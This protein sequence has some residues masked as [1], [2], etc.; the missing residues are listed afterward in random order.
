MPSGEVRIMVDDF[1]VPEVLVDVSKGL[2]RGLGEA[3]AKGDVLSVFIDIYQRGFL[4]Q[5]ELPR[6]KNK[7]LGYEEPGDLGGEEP[8]CQAVKMDF[9]K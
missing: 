9:S 7:R 6:G 5:N 1:V 2:R 4:S 3:F 8:G